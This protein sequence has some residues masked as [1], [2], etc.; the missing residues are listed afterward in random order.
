MYQLAPA[1]TPISIPDLA[2]WLHAQ[3]NQ[4]GVL[5]EFRQSIC[6]RY[7]VRYCFFVSTG[8]AAFSLVLEAMRECAS[9]EKDE[10]VIPSY[11][12]YS[13]PASVARAGLKVRICDIDPRTLDYDYIALEQADFTRVLCVASANLYG[14]PNDLPRLGAIAR[15]NGALV[16]DDAAQSMEASIQGDFSG[17]LG[18]VGIFSLDKG[19]N[20]TSIDGGIIVT[21]RDDLGSL[22]QAKVAALPE[23]SLKTRSLYLIKLLVYSSFLHPRLYWIPNGIPWLNLGSTRYTVNFLK[24]SYPVFL[25]SVGK[26]LFDRVG[27]ITASRIEKAQ[28]LIKKIKG[29]DNIQLI[30]NPSYISPV[31]LRL[32]L[33]IKRDHRDKLMI[34]LKQA[35]IGA[36]TSYP[37][38]IVDIPNID[39]NL[40]RGSCHSEAGRWVAK[41]ILTLPT[42]S[43][44]TKADLDRIVLKFR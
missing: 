6:D 1:G 18:D 30:T 26:R 20:I 28:Y 3:F 27:L 17:T 42:H 5:E 37:T 31:Y 10:V 9:T 41:M 32:P 34:R 11:T 23:P 2:Y 14:I 12:C 40:F 19:K 13:V 39:S 15:K 8:R 43:Y 29:L 25:A 7:G 4:S 35:G 21:N 38:S 33:L 22:L 44:V 16:L 24:E 36:S